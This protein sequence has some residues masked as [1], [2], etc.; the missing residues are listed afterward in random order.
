MKEAL[1]AAAGALNAGRWP[2]PHLSPPLARLR[3]EAEG[4]QVWQGPSP[5]F[6]PQARLSLAWWRDLLGRPHVRVTGRA[7][8]PDWLRDQPGAPLAAVYPER[9]LVRVRGGQ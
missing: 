1:R 2:S 9:A 4:E 8:D 5:R 3:D 7:G 6:R